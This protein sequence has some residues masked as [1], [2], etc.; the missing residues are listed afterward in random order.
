[1]QCGEL[2]ILALL[3]ARILVGSIK[4]TMRKCKE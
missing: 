2:G 4:A 1:M 3:F